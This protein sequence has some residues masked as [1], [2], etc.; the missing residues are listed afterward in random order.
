[1]PNDIQN[2]EVLKGSSAAAIYGQ[3]G[4]AGVVL[5]TTKRGKTGKTKI[6]FSQDMGMNKIAKRLGVRPWTGETVEA[7]FNAAER[8]KYEA[9]MAA[10]GKLYDFEDIIYGDTGF[11]TETRLSATGG[12]DKTKFYLGGSF[13]D[14][15]GII[16]N[17][18]FDR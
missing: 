9:T 13:R 3:R 14:E 8:A 17:T 4:N 18:G 5:I 10:N 1:D 15:G 12:S 6:S 16:K 2:I 11:I 7:T